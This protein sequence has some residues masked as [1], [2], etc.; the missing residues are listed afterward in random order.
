MEPEEL[1]AKILFLIRS[2]SDAGMFNLPNLRDEL[3]GPNYSSRPQY[4]DRHKREIDLALAEAFAWLEAQA[5]VVP[6][7]GIN[8]QNGWR[9]LS[10]RAK[11]FVDEIDVAAFTAARRLPKESLHPSISNPVWQEFIRGQ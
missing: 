2:R 3:W 7:Q 11:K 8:G 5:L 4:S 6:A 1:G 9:H 10:R